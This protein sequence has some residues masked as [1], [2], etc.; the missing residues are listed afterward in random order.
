MIPGSPAMPDDLYD[1]DFFAWSMRQADLLHRLADGE[2]VNH[3]LDAANLAEEIESLGRS[4]KRELS[5]RLRVLLAHL[6]KWQRQPERRGESWTAT[7]REQRHEIE[8]VLE[9]SP[10]LR[11][12]VPDAMATAYRRARGDA[13]SE[14]K[15]P[16]SAFPESCPWTP[17]RVLDLDYL[18]DACPT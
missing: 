2:R 17:E 6:L 11:P 3:A 8:A 14:T 13:A 5:S 15:L 16:P 4:Q 1:R 10:S 7:I 18:P 9:D 12:T